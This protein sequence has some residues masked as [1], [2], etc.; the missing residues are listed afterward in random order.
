VTGPQNRHSVQDTA[1]LGGY[2][3][4]DDVSHILIVCYLFKDKETGVE[5]EAGTS[6]TQ[7][8]LQEV[9]EFG[10]M[11]DNIRAAGQPSHVDCIKSIFETFRDF[12]PTFA[13]G[14]LTYSS[15]FETALCA[16]VNRMLR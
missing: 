4:V 3:Y 15:A 5:F 10:Q 16:M 13:F 7:P 8:S 11:W 2:V 1:T 9:E 12:L 14:V 6:V